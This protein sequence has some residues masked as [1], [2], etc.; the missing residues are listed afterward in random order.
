MVNRR[1]SQPFPAQ[2]TLETWI[3]GRDPMA[4]SINGPA[5]LSRTNSHLDR[6]KKRDSKIGR[7]RSDIHHSPRWG[8]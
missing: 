2:R 1:S 4:K 7:T 5:V 6:G 3:G 8:D